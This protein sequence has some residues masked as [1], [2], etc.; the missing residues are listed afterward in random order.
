MAPEEKYPCT[1]CGACCRQAENL[2]LLCEEKEI[3]LGFNVPVNED[4]SCGHLISVNRP[5]GAPGFGCAIYNTRPNVCKINAAIPLGVEAKEY[6]S[7]CAVACNDLQVFYG[8]SDTYRVK[9][10]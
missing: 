8:V 2:K 6:F 9:I 10:E 4:G 7:L 3:D 5:D 1:M